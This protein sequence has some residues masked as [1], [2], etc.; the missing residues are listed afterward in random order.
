[1]KKIIL[2]ILKE[3]VPSLVFILMWACFVIELSK[4]M[5]SVIAFFAGL[6]CLL[7]VI[8]GLFGADSWHEKR[9]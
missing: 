4:I 5:P 9:N 2:Q 3:L 1:M 7:V 6:A 8:A